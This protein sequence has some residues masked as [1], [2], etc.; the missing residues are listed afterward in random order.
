MCIFACV[1]VKPLHKVL[2]LVFVQAALITSSF[3][4]TSYIEIQHST[5]GKLIDVSGKNRLFVTTVQLET[6][7]ALFHDSET[8][9]H[10]DTAI[11]ELEHNVALLRHGGIVEGINISSLPPE[12]HSELDEM[13]DM[14][15]QYK[16]MVR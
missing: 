11:E 1:C 6:Y 4:V 13:A 8:H 7:R 16:I 10:V 9:I 5:G 2:S 12:L 15:D 3:L 14:I